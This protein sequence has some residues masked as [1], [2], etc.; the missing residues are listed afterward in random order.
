VCGLCVGCVRA[1]CVSVCVCVPGGEGERT[2]VCDCVYVCICAVYVY[3]YVYVYV[4]CVRVCVCTQA[5]KH[6]CRAIRGWHLCVSIWILD[7]F[8]GCLMLM[9]LVNV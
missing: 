6:S 1:V 7:V 4:L 2:Y 8:C 5:Y 3:V 9:C